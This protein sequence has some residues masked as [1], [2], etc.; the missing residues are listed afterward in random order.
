MVLMGYDASVFN[1]VQNSDN[2]HAYFDN[3]VRPF[4]HHDCRSPLQ[5]L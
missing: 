2:W 3:P 5:H 4:H 1:S